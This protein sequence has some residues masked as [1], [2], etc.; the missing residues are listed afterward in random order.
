MNHQETGWKEKGN[1]QGK[2]YFMSYFFH[3][4]SHIISEYV[5]TSVYTISVIQFLRKYI[6]SSFA[7][8]LQQI[9]YKIEQQTM[10]NGSPYRGDQSSPSETTTIS[11][12]RARA[13]FTT[14][15]CV[16]PIPARLFSYAKLFLLLSWCLIRSAQPCRRRKKCVPDTPCYLS[17]SVSIKPAI[18]EMAEQIDLGGARCSR[19]LTAFKNEPPSS[20]RFGGLFF[21]LC[22]SLQ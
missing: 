5:E 10:L 12:E 14:P 21:L 2:W 9:Y 6:V 15:E 11:S 3:P 7:S 8:H 4:S 16:S 13:A 20:N 17:I 1:R 18:K 19:E 22:F